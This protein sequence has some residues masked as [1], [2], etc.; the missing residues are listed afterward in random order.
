MPREYFLISD[1]HIGGDG[2]LASCDFE[3]ELIQFLKFFEEQEDA[4]LIINGDAF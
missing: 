2:E 3:T 4:E 1:T